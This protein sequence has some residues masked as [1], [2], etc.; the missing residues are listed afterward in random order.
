MTKP[1][2][3]ASQYPPSEHTFRGAITM[4]LASGGADVDELIE[5]FIELAADAALYFPDEAP[6]TADAVPGIVDEVVA[7][8]RAVVTE[9]SPD[10]T[11]LLTALDQL[12]EAGILFSYGNAYD[13]SEAMEQLEDAHEHLASEGGQLRG[14]LY[15]LIPDLDELVLDQRLDIAFGT[16]DADSEAVPALAEEAVR[17]LTG[18]GLAASWSGDVQEPI[19]VEPIVM[20]APLVDDSDEHEHEH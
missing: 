13:A 2:A 1:A 11:G 20:D 7:A 16:F 3:F 9:F 5:E 19:V 15:S 12:F 14:Y 10:A 18:N 6:I 8:Y 17:I 4:R